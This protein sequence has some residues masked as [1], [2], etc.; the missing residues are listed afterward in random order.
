MA[1]LLGITR[2][3]EKGDDSVLFGEADPR[4]DGTPDFVQLCAGTEQGRS[5]HQD[6]TGAA[7]QRGFSLD[8]RP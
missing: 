6:Q 8:V 1:A 7:Q 3:T 5:W 2:K 4:E